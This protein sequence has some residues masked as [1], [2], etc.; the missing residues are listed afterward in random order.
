MVLG[1]IGVM[2]CCCGG[3]IG[4][5]CSIVAWVLGHQELKAIDTG[6]SSWE[7]YGQA[8]AGMIMGIIGT[9]INALLLIGAVLYYALVFGVMIASGAGGA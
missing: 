4:L 1:I 2:T 7:G 5:I 9:I 3:W 6:E 8:R